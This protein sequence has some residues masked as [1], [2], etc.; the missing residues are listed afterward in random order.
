MAFRYPRPGALAPL[1]APA[2]GFRFDYRID[3]A[4]VYRFTDK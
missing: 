4:I 1:H 3:G 2:A